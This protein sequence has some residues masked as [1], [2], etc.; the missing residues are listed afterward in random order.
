[1]KKIPLLFAFMA[2][3]A[4]EP[5]PADADWAA[6]ESAGLLQFKAADNAATLPARER[7]ETV[8][9]H[10][11]LLREQGL[12]FYGNHPTDPRRWIVVWRMVIMP[13]RFI[14]SYGPNFEKDRRDLVIDT[15][16]AAAWKAE[17]AQLDAALSAAPDVP[18]A[19]RESLDSRNIARV[20]RSLDKAGLD[21]QTVDWAPLLARVAAFAAKYPESERAFGMLQRIMDYYEP[22][23]SFEKSRVV[24]ERF[25]GSP[26]RLLAGKAEERLHFFALAAQPLELQFTAAD[27]RAVDLEKLRG[28]VVLMDFWAT[29]CGPCIAELP[30]VKKVYAAYHDRGFEVIG[31][32]L[33]NGRLTPKDTPAQTAARLEAA[34]KVLADFT[35]ANGMPWPQYFDGKFWK[36]DIS[37][38][39]AISS[40]PAMFLLDQDGRVVSTNARGEKLEQEVKRLLKL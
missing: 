33:E 27:G 7:T 22:A 31:I 9:R 37:T 16:A 12:A 25:A 26:N 8:E 14:T 39:Y 24:W 28:K 23:N 30:N 34:K 21:L 5:A 18:V 4:A 10:S 11:R 29:W 20:L 1:M 35:A 19:V 36:N 32:A 17:L 15:A 6:L 38:K 40:I 3:I 2:A 13:P